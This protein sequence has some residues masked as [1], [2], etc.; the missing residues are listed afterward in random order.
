VVNDNA[1]ILIVDDTFNRMKIGGKAL[2]DLK[3]I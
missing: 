2:L 3:A 1:E